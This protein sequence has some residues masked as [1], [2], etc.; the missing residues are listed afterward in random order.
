[1]IPLNLHA[2]NE[3]LNSFSGVPKPVPG[4]M[5]TVQRM[6]DFQKRMR[7]IN[8]QIRELN[9]EMLEKT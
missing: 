8:A 4:T 3:A 7:D 2:I 5:E 1:M 9:K 6:K